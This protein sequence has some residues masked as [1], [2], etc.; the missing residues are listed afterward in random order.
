MP[1]PFRK[2]VIMA[3]ATT[4]K[5]DTIA[6]IDDRV[7]GTIREHLGRATYPDGNFVPAQIGKMASDLLNNA[8]CNS[9]LPS[10][11]PK[12]KRPAGMDLIAPV[13]SQ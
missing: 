3:V 13:H 5:D 8:T 12:A 11:P 7:C 9:T 1:N 6:N 2:A 10:T 4:L